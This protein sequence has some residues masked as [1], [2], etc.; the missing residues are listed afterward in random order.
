MLAR[1]LPVTFLTVFMV[2]YLCY[3]SAECIGFYAKV[4]EDRLAARPYYVWAFH[5][6]ELMEMSVPMTMIFSTGVFMAL[7]GF[8]SG[9]FIQ[10]Q[11]SV[12]H[13]KNYMYP[14]MVDYLT[15]HLE[16]I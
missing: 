2:G 14:N 15:V 7:R 13:T 16:E 6:W 1:E 4:S 9:S 3:I 10:S 8:F 5:F 12:L 11:W